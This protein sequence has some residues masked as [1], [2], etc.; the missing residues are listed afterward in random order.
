MNQ[1]GFAPII[2][3][4]IFALLAA[5]A[6]GAYFF[7]KQKSS[8]LTPPAVN[9]P[10]THPQV[11]PKAAPTPAAAA[12]TG[13][14]T[15]TG[16]VTRLST[17][18]GLIKNSDEFDS[19]GITY[20]TGGVFSSGKYAG[21]TRYLA[22]FDWGPGGPVTLFFV[23][24]DQRSYIL[25]STAKTIYNMDM[26]YFDTT[27]VVSTDLIPEA[28][29]ETIS[30]DPNFSLSEYDI[31]SIRQDTGQKS[32]DQSHSPLYENILETDFSKNKTLTLPNVSNLT[33]YAPLPASTSI[34]PYLDITTQVIVVDSTGLPYTFAI[35]TKGS[36][37]TGAN[38]NK[39]S[40]RF[41]KAQLVSTNSLYNNYDVAFPGGCSFNQYNYITKD[42]TDADLSQIATFNGLPIYGLKNKD[43]AL[44]HL[45]YD[46]KVSPY[47]QDFKDINDG[48]VAPTYQEYVAKNPLLFVKDYWGRLVVLG[49]FD[50]QLPGGCGKPVVYLYPQKSTNV[51]VSF[52]NPMILST[53]IPSYAQKWNVLAEPNGT[54]HD[55]QPNLTNCSLI[56]S[57]KIGSEYAK[58]ACLTNNYP[59]IYWA[60]NSRG[61][62]Y[63]TPTTG[64]V[65]AKDNL[66][67][68]MDKTLSDVGFT[69]K[70]KTDM[71]SY[72]VTKML[73]DNTPYYRVSFLQTQE[74]NNLIPMKITP[75]PDSI[76][77]L[78]LDY[79]P[80]SAQPKQILTPPNLTK[81]NR[82]GFF[83]LEWG[84]LIR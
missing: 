25:D 49:E 73:T 50:Y 51:Q 12:S 82:Q 11:S 56:D 38:S 58:Q 4:L 55:L 35:S 62:P 40:I 60:G 27:K 33:F 34:S 75:H 42:L 64:W 21:Y 59:Y 76:Y 41:N 84:G 10:T 63:Q 80:L 57:T 23:S 67:G 31:L 70:E 6:V 36:G 74:M 71:T 17:D 1:K 9:Y 2:F 32:D 65:V 68:F 30:L 22:L 24:K 14:A 52:I 19:Q 5:G 13:V 47:T 16:Q 45:E 72:W 78:F 15:L 79:Q 3:L 43:H 69:A 48:V 44:Y 29:P 26:S 61:T 77:R 66:A 83:V 37:D 53:A 28:T 46:T 7:Q 81:I 20:Y 8:N 54:L 18:L 39:P